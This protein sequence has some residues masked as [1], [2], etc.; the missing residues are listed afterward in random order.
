[1]LVV[2]SQLTSTAGAELMEIV[3]LPPAP[4]WRHTSTTTVTLWPALSWPDDGLVV[5]AYLKIRS[6]CVC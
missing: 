6:S 4:S 3:A 5:R 2:A 1:V